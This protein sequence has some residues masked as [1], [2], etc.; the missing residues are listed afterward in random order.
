M[1]KFKGSVVKASPDTTITYTVDGTNTFCTTLG[2][3]AQTVITVL[4]SGIDEGNFENGSVSLYPNPAS[5]FLKI[6]FNGVDFGPKSLYLTDVTGRRVFEEEVIV[7]NSNST[8]DIDVSSE[9]KGYYFLQV[10]GEKDAMIFKILI[11]HSF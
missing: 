9:K 7:S 10:K 11:D 1:N 2:G 5:D 6:N 8:F 4:P 3:Q